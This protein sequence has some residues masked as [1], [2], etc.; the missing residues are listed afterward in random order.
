MTVED[1]GGH[2]EVR[3]AGAPGLWTVPP[4]AS[5]TYGR[6]DDRPVDV[7]L[8]HHPSLSRVAGTILNNG[9][10]V[11]VLATQ[12]PATGHTVV[13]LPGGHVAARLTDGNEYVLADLSFEVQV[14]LTVASGGRT[15]RLEVCRLA[16]GGDGVVRGGSTKVKEPLWDGPSILSS[17][18]LPWQ[19]AVAVACTLT[20]RHGAPPKASTVLRCC[21]QLQPHRLLSE[22]W[23]SDHLDAALSA[24]GLERDG[25]DKIPRIV[26]AVLG[27]RLIGQPTLDEMARRL[28]R[29]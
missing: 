24:L 18:N 15:Y 17:P 4:G 19:G 10:S 21:Q 28:R 16:T 26:A 3:V 25:R 7:R 22:R 5:L 11:R 23:L 20:Q 8:P 6:G 14:R 1:T 13:V 2:V 27:G 9:S 29:A 12:L